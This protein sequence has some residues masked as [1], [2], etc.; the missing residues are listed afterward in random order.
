MSQT[1]SVSYL[2]HDVSLTAG[3]A[4][5]LQATRVAPCCPGAVG[6]VSGRLT[7][8]QA[9]LE[10]HRQLGQTLQWK[11]FFIYDNLL[12]ILC[13]FSFLNQQ[14][15]LF[16]FLLSLSIVVVIKHVSPI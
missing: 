2:P 5:L 12:S 14:I 3:V 16:Y 8:G 11:R 15:Y 9:A 7:D 1:P 6:R 13:V 10:V 4:V